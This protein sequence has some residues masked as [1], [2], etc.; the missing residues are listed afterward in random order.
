M[1]DEGSGEGDGASVFHN[2]LYFNIGLYEVLDYNLKNCIIIP[3]VK[4]IKGNFPILELTA[5]LNN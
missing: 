3:N 2:G 1:R 4:I 5:G